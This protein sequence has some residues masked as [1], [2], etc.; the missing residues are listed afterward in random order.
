MNKMMFFPSSVSSNHPTPKPKRLADFYESVMPP[1]LFVR[2]RIYELRI[3]WVRLLVLGLGLRV[4]L[5]L[6][7]H[8]GGPMGNTDVGV[9]NR[10]GC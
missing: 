10:G 3:F 7:S 8:F 2:L 1:L 9:A 5:N 4:A 6:K